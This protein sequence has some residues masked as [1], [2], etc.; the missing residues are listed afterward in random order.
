MIEQIDHQIE[1]LTQA[2][3]A[4]AGLVDGENLEKIT[5]PAKRTAR[6]SEDGRKRL[7]AAMKK[8]WAAKRAAA[9][10]KTNKK[11]ATKTSE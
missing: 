6:F 2:R 3:A 11:G 7:A 4:L 8:R 1:Q 9:R 5:N 10:G